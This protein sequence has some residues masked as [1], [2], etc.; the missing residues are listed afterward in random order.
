MKKNNLKNKILQMDLRDIVNI[1]VKNIFLILFTTLLGLIIG[2]FSMIQDTDE[3]KFN[4]K[5]EIPE[6]N[7]ETKEILEDI[8]DSLYKIALLEKEKIFIQHL[9]KINPKL[10]IVSD[11]PNLMK[12]REN[13]TVTKDFINMII[14]D[15][16]SN[17]NLYND[18]IFTYNEKVKKD[19]S[20]ETDQKKY[21][22]DKNLTY[23]SEQKV[24]NNRTITYLRLFFA[25]KYS[26]Y[27]AENFVKILL[28]S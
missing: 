6:V 13:F 10:P 24:V 9:I 28:T 26:D 15:Y 12:T 5:I 1:L 23:L 8:T 3:R 22:I 18:L 2:Y 21:F 27:L 17:P 14:L 4:I 11:Y 25:E 20:N 16:F 7:F 19:F